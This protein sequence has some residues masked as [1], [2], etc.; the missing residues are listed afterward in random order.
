MPKRIFDLVF[1]AVALVLLCP[2][3]LFIAL[4]I[5]WDS[6][7]P[8]LFRQERVGRFG[9]PFHIRKFRTMVVDAPSRGPAITIGQDPRITRVGAWLRRTKL[10]ELPQLMDVLQGH[11][12]L[13][14]PRPEVPQYVALYPAELRERVLAV[15]PGITDPVSLKLA[16][17]AR[18]LAASADPE[19]TYREELLPA[20]LREAVA[21]AE[22]ASLWSD[23]RIIAAT[24]HRLWFQRSAGTTAAEDSRRKAG[25]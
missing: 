3:F 19:R 13:V 5:R 4:A 23:L 22:Q 8:V 25:R 16:D 9:R 12:S 24:A 14:G 11:M 7:G 17:E 10:D 2:L 21:Y 15:R 18:V 1:S 6:A 20:K